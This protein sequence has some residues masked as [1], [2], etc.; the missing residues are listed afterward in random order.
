MYIKGN[1]FKIEWR[2]KVDSILVMEM[3]M[4]VVFPMESSMVKVFWLR[5]ME[6]NWKETGL[7][8]FCKVKG[9]RNG[10][11]K[12]ITKE[13]LLMDLNKDL[14]YFI[15][16]MVRFTLES[17]IMIKSQELE[18]LNIQMEQFTKEIYSMD[19]KMEK[20]RC[21]IQTDQFMMGIG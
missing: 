7:K 13:V 12:T 20:E 3:C 21:I 14:V 1:G 19:W 9:F 8:V 15:E 5:E 2:V 16:L 11:I 18:K 10:Q 4:R 17:L 6:L